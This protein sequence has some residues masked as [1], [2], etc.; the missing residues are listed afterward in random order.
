[1]NAPRIAK[2]TV[3]A[4]GVNIFPSTPTKARIGKYTIKIMI[5]PKAALLLIFDAEVNTSLSISVWVNAS[6]RLS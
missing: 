3:L 5:S 2:P 4:I 1:M 6:F